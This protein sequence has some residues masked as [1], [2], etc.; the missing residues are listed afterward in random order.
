MASWRRAASAHPIPTTRELWLVPVLGARLLL[1]V[2]HLQ[3]LPQ[4]LRQALPERRPGV[5]HRPARLPGCP[6]CGLEV[7]V[8]H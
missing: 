4:C 6:L 7:N 5:A 8:P 1:P 2:F 3:T